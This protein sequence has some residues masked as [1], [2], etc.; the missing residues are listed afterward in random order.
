VGLV[1]LGSW[2]A[3]A[4]RSAYATRYAF[5]DEYSFARTALRALPPDC[6]VYQVPVRADPLPRDL[7]CCL[8][9]PRS[10][11]VLEFPRLRFQPMP[12]D[13]HAML[14]GSGCV[15]YFEGIGCEIPLS[16]NGL[17]GVAAEYFGARCHAARAEIPSPPVAE[18]TT[19]ARTTEG[20]FTTQPPH[21]R[22]YRLR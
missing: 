2:T 18:T 6:D 5:Q 20:F 8:D 21:V 14:S 15:A 4:S 11:V 7:D 12:P 16:E 9:L 10:P 1:V 13:A 22:L 17:S 19:S 3:V